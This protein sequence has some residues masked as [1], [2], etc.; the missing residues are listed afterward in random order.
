MLRHLFPFPPCGYQ[1]TGFCPTA[2]AR[3]EVE[4]CFPVNQK[5]CWGKVKLPFVTRVWIT[6]RVENITSEP[7]A[8]CLRIMPGI[9]ARL[10]TALR[11][12][13]VSLRILPTVP[14]GISVYFPPL[15]LLKS[16]GGWSICQGFSD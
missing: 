8:F 13:Q 4:N 1:K 11:A 2:G 10:V 16:L 6:A 9:S 14:K 12:G 5:T 3:R 7:P 15:T